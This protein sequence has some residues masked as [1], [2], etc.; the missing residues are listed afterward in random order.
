M[1]K[2]A[3]GFM[4]TEN[5][6]LHPETPLKRCA[7]IRCM[8]QLMCRCSHLK[9]IKPDSFKAITS[10]LMTDIET[11]IGTGEYINICYKVMHPLCINIHDAK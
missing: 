8:V 10:I 9:D 1:L 11:I 6:V 4:W 5:I 7:Y 2:G 3:A